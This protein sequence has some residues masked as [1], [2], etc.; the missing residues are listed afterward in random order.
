MSDWLSCNSL[1]AL[2]AEVALQT[3]AVGDVGVGAAAMLLLVG[4]LLQM[5][6]VLLLL[7]LLQQ[8]LL[9]LLQL[10]LLLRDPLTLRMPMLMSKKQPQAMTTTPRLMC[11]HLTADDDPPRFSEVIG[12]AS[13]GCPQHRA[14]P[15]N[16]LRLLNHN[17]LKTTNTNYVPETMLATCTDGSLKLAT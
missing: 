13:F 4:L 11:W 9:L 15:P 7:L 16:N 6:K 1:Q 3:S 8:L 2:A 14:R 17:Q 12:T 10:L 5:L